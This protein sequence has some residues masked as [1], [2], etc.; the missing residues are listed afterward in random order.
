MPD[1]TVLVVSGGGLSFSVQVRATLDSGERADLEATIQLGMG[2]VGG[3]PF[4]VLRWR[5]SES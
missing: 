3:R 4:R 2:S 5:D 1:G